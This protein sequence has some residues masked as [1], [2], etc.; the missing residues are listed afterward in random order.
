[1]Y[2]MA[3]VTMG[4]ERMRHRIEAREATAFHEAA[5]AR[6]EADALADAAAVAA[7]ARAAQA[8]VEAA[9][10]AH[11]ANA[12]AEELHSQ[13]MMQWV[14]VKMLELTSCERRRL[15]NLRRRNF[16][17][18]PLRRGGTGPSGPGGGVGTFGG[19]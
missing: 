10:R 1:M 2:L 8:Q 15:A 4:A 13:R 12:L 18:P 11:W 6:A 19:Q 17:G 16:W 3:Q 14:E 7:G 9:R 5:A